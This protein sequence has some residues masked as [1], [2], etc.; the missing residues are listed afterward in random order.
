M[1]DE[2]ITMY[3]NILEPATVASVIDHT[4][5]DP[6]AT[7]AQLKS[8]L[9]EAVLYGTNI[10]L[11]EGRLI[12]AIKILN[13]D[14]GRGNV[15]IACV[16]GFP[17]GATSTEI[18]VKSAQYIL[19]NGADEVDVVVNIGYLKDRDPR[20]S[21]E[22]IK[23]AEAVSDYNGVLK[24]IIETCYL[25]ITDKVEATKAVMEAADITGVTMFVKTSTGFGTPAEGIPKGATVEDVNLIHNTLNSMNSTVG[26]KASGG[27]RDLGALFSMMEAGGILGDGK[28]MISP[29]EIMW[30]FRAGTSSGGAI[31]AEMEK[32][33]N[34]E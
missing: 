1:L 20:F 21:Q 26:I 2:R 13:K 33:Q 30:H 29:E 15:R 25:D 32:Y 5:L 24:V 14:I 9:E 10:C 12:D 22:L 18:K 28:L 19:E 34:G 31:M 11:N 6:R 7:Q 17:L 16:A 3:A 23:I 8:F 27:I 4:L